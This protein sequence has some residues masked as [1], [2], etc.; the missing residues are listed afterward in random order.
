[1]NTKTAA[2]AALLCVL[3]P[4][5]PAMAQDFD[6][7]FNG[8]VGG[9]RVVAVSVHGAYDIGDLIDELRPYAAPDTT[10]IAYINHEAVSETEPLVVYVDG[11]NVAFAERPRFSTESPTF[12]ESLRASMNVERGARSGAIC[13]DGTRT[14]RTSNGACSFNGGLD[15]WLYEG[16]ARSDGEQVIAAICEDYRLVAG[17]GTRCGDV[18]VLTPIYA[19]VYADPEAVDPAELEETPE[20]PPPNEREVAPLPEPEVV[21]PAVR[22]SRVDWTRRANGAVGFA[23]MT[24]L[25]NGNAQPVRAVVS[26]RLLDAD[27]EVIFTDERLVALDGGASGEFTDEGRVPEETALRGERWTFDVQ[28]APD[29]VPLTATEMSVVQMVVEPLIEEVRITNTSDATL[30]LNG[31]TLASTVGEESFT[32][33]FFKLEAGKT[34]TLTSGDGARSLLPEVYLWTSREVWADDGD[35]AELRDQRGRL[36]ARTHP[37]GTA[38]AL[39]GAGGK[40][41]SR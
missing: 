29:E 7:I 20:P 9:R 39:D 16:V 24:S 8:A 2:L 11:E 12:A 32:F 6:T 34:V 10:L 22:D 19:R 28:L 33:R 13:R 38:A 31:W 17:D 25:S 36:R 4:A 3:A 14:T 21:P 26:A 40:R 37:D 5:S 18:D 23:W 1:M 30:D 15:R 41:V 27:G 35:A